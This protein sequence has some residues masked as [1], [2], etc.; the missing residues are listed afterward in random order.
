MCLQISNKFNQLEQ[1]A[2]GRVASVEMKMERIFTQKGWQYSCMG[3]TCH[4]KF[5]LSVKQWKVHG[6]YRNY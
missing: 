5:R 3:P 4:A 1:S 2:L 6:G